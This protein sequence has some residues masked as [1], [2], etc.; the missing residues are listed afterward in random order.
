[1]ADVIDQLV[2]DGYIKTPRILEAFRA[3][4]RADFLP[5]AEK[6]NANLNIPLPIGYGQTNSQPLTVAFMLELLQPKPGDR[7]LDVGAGSGWTAALFAHIVG[8]K[9]SVVAVER[10]PQLHRFAA[11]NLR[12]YSFKNLK[13][14][15]R[16]ATEKDPTMPAY[17][18][19]HV[20]AAAK[21]I[22]ALFK[23][24]LALGG[25]LLVPVG[26]DLQTLVMLTKTGKDSFLEQRYPGFSFVPLLEGSLA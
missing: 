7:V 22:P 6:D 19:M 12:Q 17:D 11:E 15:R 2:R 8:E 25:R 5:E 23:E 16:D 21:N 24:Q 1:M 13:L 14:V 9:G 10:I 26:E 3:V 18:V 20:A 4:S